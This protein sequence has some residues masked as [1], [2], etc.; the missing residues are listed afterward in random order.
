MT[1]AAIKAVFNSALLTLVIWCLP[2]LNCLLDLFPVRQSKG[3]EQ[4]D[5]LRFS[6]P[7]SSYFLLKADLSFHDFAWVVPGAVLTKHE[8]ATTGAVPDIVALA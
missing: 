7:H 3:A 2:V 4:G 5:S 1:S 6:E 8:V